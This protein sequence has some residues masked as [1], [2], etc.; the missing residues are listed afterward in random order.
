MLFQEVDGNN[1]IE[2]DREDSVE[3]QK[4]F[5]NTKFN[6]L[7]KLDCADAQTALKIT[8]ECLRILAKARNSSYLFTF[9]SNKAKI[10]MIT[11]TGEQ[12]PE[13]LNMMKLEAGPT[14]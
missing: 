1:F 3:W 12:I 13:I 2:V 14:N 8:L 5:P 11:A 9:Y 7:D 4:K 10:Y 6:R